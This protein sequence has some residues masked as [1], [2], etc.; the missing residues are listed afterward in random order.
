MSAFPVVVAILICF[1][2]NY[3]ACHTGDSFHSRRTRAAIFP[4]KEC[5]DNRPYPQVIPV[6]AVAGKDLANNQY[7]VCL[8]QKPTIYNCSEGLV[9]DVAK[10][11]CDFKC[12]LCVKGSFNA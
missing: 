5:P 11:S 9:F 10:M 1:N 2:L 6:S 8:R 4:I 7:V 12:D 3:G